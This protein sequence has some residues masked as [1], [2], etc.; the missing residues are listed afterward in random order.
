MSSSSDNNN[1][2]SSIPF[3]TASELKRDHNDNDNN[4]GLSW[5]K[6]MAEIKKKEEEDNAPLH[7]FGKEQEQGEEKNI[8]PIKG[9]PQEM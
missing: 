8:I 1:N 2:S 4:Q 7:R 6:H 5:N 9:K 3:P